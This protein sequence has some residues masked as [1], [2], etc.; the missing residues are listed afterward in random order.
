MQNLASFGRRSKKTS[1]L[2]DTGLCAGNSPGIGE[3]PT[4][5]AG[6]A[7]NVSIWWRHH[8][9]T[10][11]FWATDYS[12]FNSLRPRDASKLIIIGPYNGLSP[13]RRQAIIWTNTGIL[14]IRTISQWNLN[15]DSYIFIRENAFENIVWK[16]VAIL[17][18]PQCP[19]IGSQ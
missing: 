12:P 1:K 2:R 14:L 17:S 9:G 6:N 13:G 5:M 11:L 10:F 18:W 3:F 8:A 15:R 19:K 16:M 4:Q 7:E